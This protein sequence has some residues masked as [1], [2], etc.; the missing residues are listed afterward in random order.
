MSEFDRQSVGRR[1]L[2]R[3]AFII[4]V[5]AATWAGVLEIFGGFDLKV[6][7]HL[8]TSN[9]P[10]RLWIAAIGAFALFFATGGSVRHVADWQPGPKTRALQTMLGGRVIAG[11]GRV[12]RV[13]TPGRAALV[14]AA[15]TFVFGVAYATT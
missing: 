2:Q 8:V 10:E 15:A 5:I 4:G 6:L 14:L 11:L 12:L 3:A 1:R 13:V 7:G 9:N